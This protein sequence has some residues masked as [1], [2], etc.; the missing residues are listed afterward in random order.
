MVVLLV[1]G[2]VEDWFPLMVEKVKHSLAI[3]VQNFLLEYLMTICFENLV[4]LSDGD[5]L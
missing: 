1:P 5:W 3:G 4:V 2:Q